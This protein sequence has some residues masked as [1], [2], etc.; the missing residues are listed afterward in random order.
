MKPDFIVL[1]EPVSAL[2]VSIQAQVLNILRE[3]QQKFGLTY[4]FVAHNLAVVEHISDRVAVMYLG[5]MVELADRVG[6]FSQPLHPYTRALMSAI[7]IPNPR[8]K[9]ERIILEGDVPSPLNPPSGCR[10]HPRCP[11]AKEIC[12]NEEPVF[13]EI[14]PGHSV[15]CHFVE[16]FL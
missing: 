1:D 7:P 5:K 16:D 12:S 11:F 14:K 10:F 3:L 13:K 6:L 9:R 2:D 4:L 15:A 8:I